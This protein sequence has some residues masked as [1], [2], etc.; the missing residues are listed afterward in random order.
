VFGISRRVIGIIFGIL[1]VAFA[2][3]AILLFTPQGQANQEG[4]TVM[5]VN[6]KPVN[7]LEI[8]RAKG[9]NE[10]FSAASEGVIKIMIDTYLLEQIILQ[11]AVEQDAARM[12]VSGNDIRAEVDRIKESQG[13][14]TQEDYDRFLN[15]V[16]Y[17]DSQL[18]KEIKSYL[19]IQKRLEQVRNQA[20]PSDAELDLHFR[21]SKAAYRNDERVKAYQIVLDN[22]D[23]ANEIL[24]KAKA[25]EDFAALAKENSKVGKEQNGALGAKSGT[26]EPQ[27]VTRAVF[28]AAVATEVFKSKAAGL[29]GPIEA[30]GRFYLIKVEEY[31]P[32]AEAS[33][34]E[35]KDKITED[36]KNIKQEEAAEQYIKEVR[37]KAKVRFAEN[38]GYIYENPVVAKVGSEEI[39]LTDLLGV[40]L[41]NQ[42]VAGFIQQNAGDLVVQLLFP[43]AL[44]QQIRSKVALTQATEL[45]EPFFGTE[46]VRAAQIQQFKTLETTV[47]N[48]AIAL[49]YRENLDSYTTPA[50]AQVSSASFT[51]RAAATA[52]RSTL[53]KA[54]SASKLDALVKTAKGTFKTYGQVFPGGDLPAVANRLVFE[55]SGTFARSALG[56]VSEVVKITTDGKDS[57]QI[58]VVNARTPKTVK[59]FAEVQDELRDQVTA[60]KRAEEASK[61]IETV[62]TTLNP[63]NNFSAV[64]TELTKKATTSTPP[65]ADSTAAPADGTAAPADGTEAP[66]DNT[67]P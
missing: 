20:K 26:T 64:V 11:R 6:N 46:N 44:E 34:E 7:S 18:R 49:A 66:A 58:F 50:S 40:A 53:L 55:T 24:T 5:W 51:D 17:T 48:A 47:D 32:A 21:L 45:K 1:A 65:P 41:S 3:G 9:S 42:Q 33:F 16:G 15:N 52:F 67:A 8:D 14:K 2:L 43:Q 39:K 30:G 22:K 63:E 36:V 28:P 29:V 31:L 19:Q 25:G 59:S 61:W 38:S 27:P 62:Q 4:P 56:E 57:F 54:S 13:I 23:T 12:R 35:S 60:T 37:A 10:L